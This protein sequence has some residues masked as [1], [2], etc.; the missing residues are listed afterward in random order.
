MRLDLFSLHLFADIVETR[1]I[2]KGAKRH[3]LAVSAA[4][5]RIADLEYQFGTEL[6]RR[7]ARGVLPT[8]AGETLYGR[9]RQVLGDL[10]QTAVEMSEYAHGTRGLVRVCSNLTAMVQCLP[11]DLAGF[12][13]EHPHIGMAL[14][15]SSTAATLQAVAKGHAD[16]GIV[17]PV[18]PY[19]PELHYWHY[20]TAT[21]AVVAPAG[22]PLA[23]RAAVTYAETLAYPYIGLETGGGW[24][25]L[26]SR[27]AEGLGTVMNIK[28]RVNGFE[29]ACRMVEA[30]LGLT[31][32]PHSS[33][34]LHAGA[35]GLKV[36]ALDEEWAVVPLDVCCRDLSQL[37][38]PARLMVRHL[39][40]RNGTRASTKIEGLA[41]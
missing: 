35:L 19:L 29:A 32:V 40:T 4:S 34:V 13:Q 41:A 3:N 39:I 8:E 20:S 7:H 27:K 38:V 22:H 15:E 25:R 16:V 23:R 18:V 33:A 28:V 21:H 12:A 36:L 14:Q 26:L 10:H 30:G 9:I 24:D 17:A 1:S 2:G 5:K 6:L 31:L 37:P 11:Q